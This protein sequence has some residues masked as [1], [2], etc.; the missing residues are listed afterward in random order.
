MGVSRNDEHQKD[1]P[2]PRELALKMDSFARL[3]SLSELHP[4]ARLALQSSFLNPMSTHIYHNS[5]MRSEKAEDLVTYQ[6]NSG[7]LAG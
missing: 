1:L 4:S 2:F 3:S 5:I 6:R 7:S